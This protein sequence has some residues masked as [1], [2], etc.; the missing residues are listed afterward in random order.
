MLIYLF[1]SLKEQAGK[2]YTCTFHAP[3]GICIE[4]NCKEGAGEI[5]VA[6]TGVTKCIWLGLA[7][8]HFQNWQW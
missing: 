8:Y 2:K 3:N 6:A 7:S 1:V 5:T 4:A